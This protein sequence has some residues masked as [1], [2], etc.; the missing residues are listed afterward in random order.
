MLILSEVL[1]L[2]R[3]P[4]VTCQGGGF[5]Q[6]TWETD[7]LEGRCLQAEEPTLIGYS[8]F[9]RKNGPECFRPA[10]AGCLVVHQRNAPGFS[11]EVEY[12]RTQS[13]HY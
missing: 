6:L 13:R 8:C 5:L 3:L 9:T 12:V 4:S 7:L 11:G 1:D 10:A 2:G